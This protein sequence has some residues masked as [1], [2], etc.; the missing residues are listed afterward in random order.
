MVLGALANVDRCRNSCGLSA[1]WDGIKAP[2]DR[3]VAV[4]PPKAETATSLPEVEILLVLAGGL[5][6]AVAN[7]L[8][9]EFREKRKQKREHNADQRKVVADFLGSVAEMQHHTHLLSILVP[10]EDTV[11]EGIR[12]FDALHRDRMTI[13]TAY[14]RTRLDVTTNPVR[15]V[16]DRTYSVAREIDEIVGNYDDSDT[17]EGMQS[18]LSSLNRNLSNCCE[19]TIRICEATIG[20]RALSRRRLRAAQI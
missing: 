20:P 1:D 6:G 16:V 3:R 19:A 9:T 14:A 7:Q 2:A 15:Y 18:Q 10:S 17:I 4:P 12:L 5:A 13:L 8:S 11:D